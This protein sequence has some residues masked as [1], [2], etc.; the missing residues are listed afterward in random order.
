MFWEINDT[1]RAG[2]AGPDP[3]QYSEILAYCEFQGI[4]N[5]YE[6]KRLID[7]V[8]LL[9]REYINYLTTDGKKKVT[10]GSN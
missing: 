1:R 4:S 9:D 3:I 2:F 6:R 8:R 5:A 7:R 10:D